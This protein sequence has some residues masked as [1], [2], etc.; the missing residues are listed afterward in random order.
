[1]GSTAFD[2][3]PTNS[4][5]KDKI[6]SLVLPDLVTSI[7]GGTSSNPSFKHF[8]SLISVTGKNVEIIN[9]SSSSSSYYYGISAFSGCTAL[10]S[11]NFP[12]A[13]S[14]DHDAFSGCTALTSVSLP[15]ATSIGYSAFSGCTSLTSVSLPAATSIGDS[16]FSGCT[17]LTSVSLPEVTSI[18]SGFY[19]NSG[20]FSGCTALTSMSLPASLTTID[21]RAFSGCTNLM[22]ITVDP[23]NPNYIAQGG[24]LLSKDGTTLVAY[25]SA[26]GAVTLS[27]ITAVGDSAF[28]G[29]SALT[30][31]SL[32]VAATIGS[33]AF[34]GCTTLTSVSLPAAT[35]IGNS[36]FSSCT[37]L[38]SMSLPASPPT[39]NA[40]VFSSTYNSD[41]PIA[42]LTITVPL[43]AAGEYENAWGVST[44]TAP[45][46][47][48]KYGIGHK[49]INIVEAS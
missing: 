2:P 23:G 3:D 29:C 38:T 24:K 47:T 19:K 43:A 42:T 32:P 21:G 13:T 35:S 39:L 26:T 14:I 15:A 37:A 16:A 40:M 12:A 33:S 10:T 36:A 45:G 8:S 4:D 5:G 6:A 25:P 7:P 49:A 9:S 31:V 27:G 20:A 30:S 1:M 34:S 41:N 22:N 44:N 28:S 18:G 46:N 11:V 48:N 17:A